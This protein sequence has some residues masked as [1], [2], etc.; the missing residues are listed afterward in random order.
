MSSS[1]LGSRSKVI[2]ELG[3]LTLNPNPC[4]LPISRGWGGDMG[5]HLLS[6]I[7]LEGGGGRGYGRSFAFEDFY[8]FIGWRVIFFTLF[9]ADG[10]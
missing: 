2:G 7:F 1:K 8:V 10:F 9:T 3:S 6:R 4:S 5:G